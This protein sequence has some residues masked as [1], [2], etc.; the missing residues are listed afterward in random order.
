M[1]L[2]TQTDYLTHR[3]GIEKGIRM[4]CE[5]GF[6]AL[7]FSMFALFSE[8]NPLNTEG[9]GYVEN[10]KKIASEYG[11][12]FNQ[13]HAPFPS[14]KEKD[15]E[16]N[17]KAFKAIVR[18]MEIC[19]I[20]EIGV[21][22]VHPTDISN[23]QEKKQYNLDFYN[24]LL[25]YCEKYNVKVALENMW[26]YDS[27]AKKIIPNVCSTAEE[28]AEYVDALDSKYFTVCLDL[29][30]CGLVGEDAANMIRVLG[31]DRL[32][33]LHV[34]D[35][36]GVNDS[37][38][39]PFFGVMDWNSITRALAEIDY[40]GD[41]TFEADNFFL[42]KPDELLPVT[43]RYMHDIGRVLIGMIENAKVGK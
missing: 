7:D 6:D 18:A 19:N 40:V 3:F 13:A 16:Y 11:V 27:V 30:H 31:H 12:Y 35:N 4:L 29:G 20:L 10:I 38:T 5:A 17:K 32:T 42:R 15:E 22:I 14:S 1:I 25:P 41:F 34:H 24:R 43:A 33:S 8:K 2:S 9:N 39:A 36:D 21:V 28:L 37:H 23:K 26:G